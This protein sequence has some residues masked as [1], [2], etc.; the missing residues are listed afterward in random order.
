MIYSFQSIYMWR[1]SF[2]RNGEACVEKGNVVHTLTIFQ[3]NRPTLL[4][5][6]ISSWQ[7]IVGIGVSLIVIIIVF[8]IFLKCG[9][10]QSVRRWNKTTED[11]IKTDTVEVAQDSDSVL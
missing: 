4:D 5:D 9:I 3:Y 2:L 8:I 1:T 11:V 10:F 6:I 7:W